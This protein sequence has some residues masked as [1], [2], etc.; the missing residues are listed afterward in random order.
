MSGGAAPVRATILGPDRIAACGIVARCPYQLARHLIAAG[1]DRTRP[2]QT[3]W[4][5]GRPSMRF[6]SLAAA[7]QWAVR[8]SRGDGPRRVRFR[9]PPQARAHDP[10]NA[11][12]FSGAPAVGGAQARRTQTASAMPGPDTQGGKAPVKRARGRAANPAARGFLPAT[13]ASA[14]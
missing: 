9:P 11:R 13:D 7:A 8:E 5:D 1:H 4:Q 6:A 14:I 12:G 10:S 2:M 3:A